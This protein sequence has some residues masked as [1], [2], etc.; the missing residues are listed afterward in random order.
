MPVGISGAPGIACSRERAQNQGRDL[1][2]EPKKIAQHKTLVHR[3]D[4]GVFLA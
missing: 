4:D 2:P 1:G 3:G